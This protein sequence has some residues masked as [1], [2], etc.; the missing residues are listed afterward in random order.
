MC[1]SIL[2]VPSAH[3]VVGST[4]SLYDFFVESGGVEGRYKKIVQRGILE[5]FL[6]W[7]VKSRYFSVY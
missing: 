1:I 4:G 3:L 6:N 5:N 2:G 7:V